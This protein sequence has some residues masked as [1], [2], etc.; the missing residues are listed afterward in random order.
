MKIVKKL[1]RQ[2]AVANYYKALM[3]FTINHFGAGVSVI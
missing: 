3:C 2:A 1:R